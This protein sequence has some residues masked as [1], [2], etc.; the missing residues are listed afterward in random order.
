MSS[1]I[2]VE[3]AELAALTGAQQTIEQ[4][5]PLILCELF[6]PNQQ[7]FGHTCE[8]IVARLK[9]RQYEGF[10]VQQALSNRSA[11]LAPLTHDLQLATQAFK[12]AYSFQPAQSAYAQAQVA[13]A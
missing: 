6:A 8:Q 12:T 2:K 4:H 5:R 3:G 7:R 9:T 10:W 13:S 11:Q 1:D